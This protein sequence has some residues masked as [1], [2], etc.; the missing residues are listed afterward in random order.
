MRKFAHL[1]TF[2]NYSIGESIIQIKKLI[3][4]SDGLFGVFLCDRMNMFAAVEFTTYAI[5]SKIK[6]ILG[7]LINIKDF[8]YL[9]FYVQDREGYEFLSKLISMA[10]I[11]GKDYVEIADLKDNKGVIVLTGGEDSFAYTPAEDDEK[12]SKLQLLKDLFADR[13]YVE[14]QKIPGANFLLQ[15]AEIMNLPIVATHSTYFLDDFEAFYIFKLTHTGNKFDETEFESSPLRKCSFIKEEFLKTFENLPEAI[16]NTVNIVK[17]CNFILEEKKPMFPAYKEEGN[18]DEYSVLERK[19]S[20]A[21][22][23]FLTKIPEDS[24]INYKKRLEKELSVIKLRG[25][26]GYF[27]VCS[28]FV[29]YARK[30]K[31]TVGC[32]GSGAGSLCAYLLGITGIDPIQFDLVFERF[33]NPERPSTPDLDI[34]FAPEKREEIINYMRQKYGQYN[35][36]HIVTFGTLQAKGA[37]RD[38]A[39]AIGIPYKEADDICK[40]IPVDAVKVVN[41]ETAISIVPELQKI[42]NNPRYSKLIDIALK[43]EGLCRNVSKHAAGIIISNEEIYKYC[44]LYADSDGILATQFN[45]KYV[46]YV[47]LIK[48]D[49]LGVKTLTIIQDTVDLVK[50]RK[51][52]DLNGI[53]IIGKVIPIDDVKTFETFCNLNLQGV[54][55]F[56]SFFVSEIIFELK[57]SCLDH[58]IA[59]NALCRPGAIK[60]LQSYIKRKHGLEKVTY[61]HPLLESILSSTYGYPIYQEQILQIAMICAGYTLG[62]A[63][64]L[65]RAMGKKLPAEMAAQEKIFIDGCLKNNI[66]LEV[67]KE[68][69]AQLNEFAGYGFN[70]SHAAV[71]AYIGYVCAY[72]KTHYPLEFMVSIMSSDMGDEA[73]TIAYVHNLY[74]MGIPILPPSVQYSKDKFTIE[75]NSIRF[76]LSAVKNVGE[77]FAKNMHEARS[78]GG[79]TSLQDF[80]TRNHSFLNRRQLEFLV[81][82]GSLD[83]ACDRESM[84]SSIEKLSEGI[85]EITPPDRKWSYIEKSE[86]EREALG[87]YINHPMVKYRKIMEKFGCITLEQTANRA[88]KAHNGMSTNYVCGLISNIKIKR[89]RKEHSTT[90][91]FFQFSDEYTLADFTVFSKVLQ[92]SRNRLKDGNLVVIQSRAEYKTGLVRN[93]CINVIE[94]EEFIQMF[95]HQILITLPSIYE[96][97]NLKEYIEKNPGSTKIAINIDNREIQTDF[98][99]KTSIEFIEF[100]MEKNID[101]IIT[102]S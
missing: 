28:D 51:G 36:A 74:K 66:N 57:P 50:R 37:I 33:I 4:A 88:K 64:I 30:N 85:A 18:A 35:I 75:C 77:R 3:D 45:M 9:P 53:D 58:L 38:V 78:E 43:L 32:R 79:Y 54:F 42:R 14:I 23:T 39:R 94:M 102:K 65:R 73:K 93:I 91:A 97:K 26:A 2:S 56:E 31:I 5:K 40:I 47:G 84:I 71:Y 95:P 52:I 41:L 82:S 19:T 27:L 101:F 13:L 62:G 1:R 25:I 21:L 83:F 22:D 60:H 90:Y 98:K 49:F 89:T 8:G 100:L 6:P 81:Y 34:D 24:H 86:K 11:R 59:I 55:Q 17:R 99:I 46:E 80:L 10:Y 48:F 92:D 12:I 96:A 68:L 20:E 16:E 61:L 44:P 7:C 69:F 70:K 76:G 72:L 87:V 15:Q 29:G 63:D 67:A